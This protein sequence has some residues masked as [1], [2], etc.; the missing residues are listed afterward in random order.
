MVGL[1]RALASELARTGVTVNAVCPGFVDTE[2]AGQAISRI[3]NKTKRTPE[4]ARGALEDLNPQKRL[5]TAGEV[6]HV[7]GMLCS[8]EARGINGQAIAIDGGQVMR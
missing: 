1:T 2:M 5:I 8:D 7:V 3:A 6:A 4:Q